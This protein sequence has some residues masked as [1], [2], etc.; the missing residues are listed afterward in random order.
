MREAG[1]RRLGP[2][3]R[4]QP[5]VDGLDRGLRELG[6][7]EDAVSD[8]DGDRQRNDDGRCRGRDAG[9][10]DGHRLARQGSRCR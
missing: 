4:R 9:K 3:A 5:C 8:D 2:P 10:V 1:R 6:G 7:L